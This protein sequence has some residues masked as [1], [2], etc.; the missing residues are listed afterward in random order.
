MI[1]YSNMPVI[2]L[3][4]YWGPFSKGKSTQSSILA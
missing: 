3:S 4:I 2:V 1:D